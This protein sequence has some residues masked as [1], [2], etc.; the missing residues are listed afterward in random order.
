MVTWWTTRSFRHKPGGSVS[1]GGVAGAG[2]RGAES[3]PAM[4]RTSRAVFMTPRHPCTLQTA[5]GRGKRVGAGNSASPRSSGGHGY[6]TVA[7]VHRLLSWT[8][9]IVALVVCLQARPV[10]AYGVLAHLALVDA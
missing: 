5:H 8:T 3:A 6:C 10:H 4:V 2:F 1:P 9:G 7:T